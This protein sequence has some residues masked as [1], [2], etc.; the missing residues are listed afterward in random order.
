[1]THPLSNF[2]LFYLIK[3]FLNL[4]IALLC[5]GYGVFGLF[6]TDVFTDLEPETEMPFNPGYIF[7][8]IGGIGF[9]ISLAFT[10]ITF[11]AAKYLKTPRKYNF[12]MVAAIVN[13][14][15]GILGILLGVFTIIELN[16]PE[17]KALF[18]ENKTM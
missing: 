9:I 18:E 15:T 14:L 3:G 1:M 12:I 2:R 8:I 13:C 6:F 7:A 10:I 11:M 16:K 17:V 4:L 5:L